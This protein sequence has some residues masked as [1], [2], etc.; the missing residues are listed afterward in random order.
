[1]A[2]PKLT[3]GGGGR[4]IGL[5]AQNQ[6]LGRR[7]S[8]GAERQPRVTAS[9]GCLGSYESPEAPSPTVHPLC[10]QEMRLSFPHTLQAACA[11]W[12]MFFP[13]QVDLTCTR[14]HSRV[15]GCRE[16][17]RRSQDCLGLCPPITSLW[18]VRQ[19]RNINGQL[20]SAKYVLFPLCDRLWER[21]LGF[22]CI[23]ELPAH[24]V[25]VSDTRAF[26]S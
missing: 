18:A 17:E 5:L 12:G 1:M 11:F 16:A 24:S 6:V 3:G 8:V 2:Y 7:C 22:Q 4:Q 13:F 20:H 9:R 14:A 25:G 10:P 26:L 15:S 19:A 23:L 21:A